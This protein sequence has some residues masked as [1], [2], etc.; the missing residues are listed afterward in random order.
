MGL[1]L[2]VAAVSTARRRRV[3]YHALSA[4]LPQPW[5]LH[6]CATPVYGPTGSGMMQCLAADETMEPEHAL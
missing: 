3:E 2:F 5:V 1:V 6:I 4:I